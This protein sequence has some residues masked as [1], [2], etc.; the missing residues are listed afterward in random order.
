MA[1]RMYPNELRLNT[2]NRAQVNPFITEFQRFDLAGNL[3]GGVENGVGVNTKVF[4]GLN[5]YLGF[6]DQVKITI[7]LECSL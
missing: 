2:D 5:F 7:A 4:V 6:I 3:G 1:V